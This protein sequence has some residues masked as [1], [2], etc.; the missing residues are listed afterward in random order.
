MALVGG[1][2]GDGVV[3]GVGVV[4]EQG[5]AGFDVAL[6]QV[7]VGPCQVVG[8][9]FLRAGGVGSGS[10]SGGFFCRFRRPTLSKQEKSV[11]NLPRPGAKKVAR[12]RP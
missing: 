6:A 9:G 8:E 10:V 5:D 4:L 11:D 7:F 2:V 3:V 12:R 1:E